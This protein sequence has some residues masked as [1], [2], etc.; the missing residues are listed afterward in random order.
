MI[1]RIQTLYILLFCTILF[2]ASLLPF[3]SLNINNEAL[4]FLYPT[5]WDSTSSLDGLKVYPFYSGYLVA[6]SFGILMLVNYKKRPKQL[7]YG[8][9]SYFFVL[10]TI[11]YMLFEVSNTLEILSKNNSNL[12]YNIKYLYSTYLL[13]SSLPVIFLANRAIKKDQK[14]VSSLDRL[15]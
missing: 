10:L 15:R 11:V 1:Q 3:A 5:G 2:I 7:R 13:I 14:L 8:M 6:V 9:F 4:Y 12:K